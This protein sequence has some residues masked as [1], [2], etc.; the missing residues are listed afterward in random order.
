[1]KDCLI[2]QDGDENKCKKCR[3]TT[4]YKGDGCVSDCGEFYYL[5]VS[6]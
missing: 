2:C 6:E 3:D 1:V 5:D 4:Y